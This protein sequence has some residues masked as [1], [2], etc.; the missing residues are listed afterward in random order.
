MKKSSRSW[1]LPSLKPFKCTNPDCTKSFLNQNGLKYHKAYGTCVKKAAPDARSSDRPYYCYE[2]ACG[3]AYKNM[4]GLRYHYLH[5]G[6]HGE[7]GM[8]MLTDG[9]HPPFLDRSGSNEHRRA[10][11]SRH[12]NHSNHSHETSTASSG[13]TPSAMAEDQAEQA[14]IPSQPM[15][16][17]GAPMMSPTSV[18][19][20]LLEAVNLF[21]DSDEPASHYGDMSSTFESRMA[22]Y[23]QSQHYGAASVPSD[24]SGQASSSYYDTSDVQLPHMSEA[25][26]SVSQPPNFN[27]AFAPPPLTF[28]ARTHRF[29]PYSVTSRGYLPPVMESPSKTTEA[30]PRPRRLSL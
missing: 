5:S 3:K 6:D 17:R 29:H 25:Y 8:T 7:K 9:S 10:S 13:S 18:S 27:T 4:N 14:Y 24:W 12:N 1:V 16:I 21:S 30:P 19:Q 26:Y 15:A 20:S 2:D 22:G 23:R 28:G 11:V